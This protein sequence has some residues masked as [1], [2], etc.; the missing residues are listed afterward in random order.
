MKIK[1][2]FEKI[3]LVHI[4]IVLILVI[5]AIFGYYQYSSSVPKKA[6]IE[7]S[8]TQQIQRDYFNMEDIN[9]KSKK[10][11]CQID[12]KYLKEKDY[13]N[14]VLGKGK[15][16]EIDCYIILKSGDNYYKI[17]TLHQGNTEDGRVNLVGCIKTKYLVENCEILLYDNENQILYEYVG[18]QSE[19]NN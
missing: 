10:I 7:I 12:S 8:Q 14:Y 19:G 18:G 6:N 5:F 9:N 16:R 1:E 15:A 4:V 2:V 17:K 11:T 3:E 13:D